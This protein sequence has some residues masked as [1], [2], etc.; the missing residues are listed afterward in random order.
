MAK[1]K[2]DDDPLRELR[3]NLYS[4]K[5]ST[6]HGRVRLQEDQAGKLVHGKRHAGSGAMDHLKSD[7]SGPRYQVEAK[8]SEKNS[9][10]IKVEWLKKIWL[11]A[12]MKGKVP[13]LHIR[14]FSLDHQVGQDWVMMPASE[15]KEIFE[16]ASQNGEIGKWDL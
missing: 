10:S 11:E 15:F 7:A 12:F 5:P 14:L 1:K 6:T 16:L 2:R 4:T 9:F 8:Q 13:M 3:E